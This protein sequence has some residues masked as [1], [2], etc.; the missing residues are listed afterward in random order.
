MDVSVN[1]V[2]LSQRLCT[3]VDRG[4][5]Q[6]VSSEPVTMT[7]KQAAVPDRISRSNQH[8]TTFIS[9]FLNDRPNDNWIYYVDT[10]PSINDR[11]AH[12][13]I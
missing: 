13:K 3:V 7:S 9:V 8:S 6:Y 11:V 4:Q 10:R 12:S 2:T 1:I 5:Q